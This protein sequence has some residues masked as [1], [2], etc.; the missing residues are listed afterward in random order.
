MPPNFF[1]YDI[2]ILISPRS[3]LFLVYICSIAKLFILL[4]FFH[5]SIFLQ[6]YGHNRGEILLS[7][8]YNPGM[9]TI[10]VGITKARNLI[11]FDAHSNRGERLKSAFV[12]KTSFQLSVFKPNQSDPSCRPIRTKVTSSAANENS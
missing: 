10:T 12:I 7:L 8:N 11:H 9:N 1:F 4:M 2:S 3:F 6:P 5:F